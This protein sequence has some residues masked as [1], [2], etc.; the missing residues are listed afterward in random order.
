[1]KSYLQKVMCFGCL[2]GI[3]AQVIQAQNVTT[4]LEADGPGNTVQ[5]INSVLTESGDATE[6]PGHTGANGCNNHFDFGEHIS[7]VFDDDLGKYVFKFDIHVNED[8]D[9]CRN[10]TRQRNEI[11][12]FGPSKATL[13]ATQGELVC[14]KWK[15]KL[16]T[17]FK[18]NF[19]F[20]HI[21]QLK[22]SGGA[23]DSKPTLTL[24][25]RLGG[26]SGNLELIFNPTTGNGEKDQKVVDGNNLTDFLGKWLEVTCLIYVNG[27]SNEISENNN[28]KYTD[29]Q[30]PGS[31][32]FVI[33]DVNSGVELMNYSNDDLDLDR[34]GMT[35][36][37]PK[38]GIYRSLSNSFRLR[39]ESVLFADFS[40]TEI[41]EVALSLPDFKFSSSVV[42]LNPVDDTIFVSDEIKRA[43]FDLF[44]IS[45]R[46]LISTTSNNIDV[47]SIKTGLYLL[48]ATTS[49]SHS[50][51]KIQKR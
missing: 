41:D 33:K 8:N 39:D 23:D 47:S 28:G 51:F 27:D 44:D 31:V 45:G 38:W 11:K 37:R 43:T 3:T 9:R 7:E 15:F 35:F 6:S 1:M 2:I 20:T 17:D 49:T 10:F 46:K 13:K 26:D 50:V 40:I 5:L 16:D 12:T 29:F 42:Q 24:S 30:K 25:P 14:Y 18:A 22:P 32:S 36:T 19:S 21:F 34:E 48:S 4:V